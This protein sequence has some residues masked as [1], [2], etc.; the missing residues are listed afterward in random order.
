MSVSIK[1]WWSTNLRGGSFADFTTCLSSVAFMGFFD[2]DMTEHFQKRAEKKLKPFLE[3]KNVNLSGLL[4]MDDSL[5]DGDHEFLLVFQDRV[6]LRSFNRPGSLM[7]RQRDI[8]V[9]PISKISRV[10]TDRQ[11]VFE[12][13]KITTSSDSIEFKANRWQGEQ[14][15]LKIL[16]LMNHSPSALSPSTQSDPTEQLR[17]LA[18]LHKAGV[19]T[20]DEFATKKAELLKRI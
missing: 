12:F 9:I 2:P 8:E 7:R 15:R 18:D 17:K 5:H 13:M 3:S 20:D 10:S 16:E 1:D 19:L 4:I 6:E 14:I 11:S